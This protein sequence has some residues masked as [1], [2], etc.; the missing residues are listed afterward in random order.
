[1]LDRV[2]FARRVA[3]RFG[4]TGEIVPVLTRDASL[5]A[6]RPLRGGVVV[7]RAAA[8]LREKP[9]G[10]DEAIRRFREEWRR[11]AGG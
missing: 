11:R 10:I 3:A 6:P 5:L 7:E 1:M 8:L 2:D 9:L 4:L